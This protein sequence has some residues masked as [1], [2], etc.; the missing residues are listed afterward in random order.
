[1][2]NRVVYM[3]ILPGRTAPAVFLFIQEDDYPSATFHL[4]EHAMPAGCL[5]GL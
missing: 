3:L 4:L 1:M 2:A 5:S